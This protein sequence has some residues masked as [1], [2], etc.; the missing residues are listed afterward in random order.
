[1]NPYRQ[2][3]SST[4]D[5]PCPRCQGT[6]TPIKEKKLVG[7]RCSWCQGV[8]IERSVLDEVLDHEKTREGL[9]PEP[10]RWVDDGQTIRC[11]V[12]QEWMQRTVCWSEPRV[13]VDVCEHGI[14]LDRGE[15]DAL[16]EAF[17]PGVDPLRQPE[18]RQVH[19]ADVGHILLDVLLL[20]L[21]PRF[22]RR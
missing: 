22:W 18:K 14:W 7:R 20:I 15:L 11:S 12:C 4:R 13:I 8:W 10:V 6:L 17:P 1:L 19:G 21:R 3:D 9:G 5:L 2:S 16:I